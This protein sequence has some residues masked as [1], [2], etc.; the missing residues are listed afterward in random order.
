MPWQKP[1][2]EMSAFK[3][4]Q[5]HSGSSSGPVVKNRKQAIAIEL[6]EQKKHGIQPKRGPRKFRRNAL[7]RVP[8]EATDNLGK[9]DIEE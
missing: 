4:G 6:S 5:L 3:A 9:V 2:D 8:Q 1:G 7:T